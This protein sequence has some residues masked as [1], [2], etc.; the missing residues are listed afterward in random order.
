MKFLVLGATGKTGSLFIRQALDA[1]HQ[2]AAVVRGSDAELDPR[3]PK[4]TGDVTRAG[5][6]AEAAAG[7][8]AIVSMLGPAG[9]G[10][11]TLITD[12]TRA[13]SE[14]ARKSGVSRVLIMSAFGVGDSLRLASPV[15]RLMYRTAA[16]AIYRDK[17]IGDAILRDSELDWTLAYPGTLKDAPRSRYDATPLDQ[18]TKVPGLVTT[19]RANVADFL[20]T[21]AADHG[22]SRR[23]VVLR[24]QK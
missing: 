19:S 13:I 9:L 3:A 18:L 6:L 4:V 8:D 11:T 23:T 21:S 22:F 12:S 2:I 17:A 16:R 10:A 14:A 1:G 20:L 5:D 15:A 24:D 7:T